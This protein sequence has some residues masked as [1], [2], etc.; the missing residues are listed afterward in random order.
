MK[1]TVFKKGL[2]FIVFFLVFTSGFGQSTNNDIVKQAQQLLE[3][4]YIFLDK[5]KETNAHLDA[6]MKKGYFD[7][8]Q[9][10]AFAKAMTEEMQKITKDKH[11]HFRAPRTQPSSKDVRPITSLISR[12]RGA[13]MLRGFQLFDSNIGYVDLAFFGGS[14]E[15]LA[16]IDQVMQNMLVA[17]VIIFDM[18]RNGGGD[19]NTVNYLSSYFFDEKL[20]L[21]SIYSRAQNHTEELW[22]VDVKGEKR[23]K[24]PVYI[25][26]SK[27]TFSGAEDFSYTMQSRGRAVVVGEVTGG[28]AHPTR[29]FPLDNGFGIGIPFARTINTVTKTNWEGTGVQPDIEMPADDALEKVKS[30]AVNKAKD[31]KNLLFQPLEES[32]KSVAGKM[33]SDTDKKKILESFKELVASNILGEGSINNIGY[34]YL[35]I[36]KPEVAMVIFE[37]NTRLFPDSANTWDSLAESYLDLGNKKKAKEYYEKAIKMDPDGGVGENARAMLKKI[38]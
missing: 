27:R 26:T 29:G 24:V 15:H 38:E 1:Q 14:E 8:M 30:L 2:G 16:K 34:S 32:F 18:R 36:E 13:P 4:N 17:D 12:Y 25:L 37:C 22:V 3:E 21:N 19:P 23:P 5:A 9:P 20:L 7:K 6:L 31:Y 35:Q 10:S 33:A 28:G 11:L